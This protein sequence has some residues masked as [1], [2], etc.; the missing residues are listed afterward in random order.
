M[1]FKK[2]KTHAYYV[3]WDSNSS[4]SEDEEKTPS[5]SLAGIIINKNISILDTPSCLMSKGPKVQ[6]NERTISESEDEEPF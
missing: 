2:N 5:T 6:F 1:S 3:E 4:T